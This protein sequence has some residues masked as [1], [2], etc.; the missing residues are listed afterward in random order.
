MAVPVTTSL[1]PRCRSSARVL[2]R[3]L[4]GALMTSAVWPAAIR[5]TAQTPTPGP[6]LLALLTTNK[7]CLERGD[8]AT[9]TVGETII[10]TL[11]IRSATLSQAN[12]TL[13]AIRPNGFIS[14][15]SLG[16]L[17]TNQTFPI[18]AR[19]GAPAG[20]HQL[21]LS[22]RAGAVTS[23][24][25]CTF[26][27]VSAT[28]TA[29]A[30]STPT[31]TETPTAASTTPTSTPAAALQPH[32]TT[33]RGCEETG[34]HPMFSIGEPITVSFDIA[35]DVVPQTRATLSDI[36][37]NGFVNVFPFGTV[38]TNHI[39]SF[40]GSIAPPTGLEVLQLRASSFGVPWA[41]SFCSFSVVPVP[42]RTRIP[43]R[44]PT[45]TR[46][47]PVATATPTP[48]PTPT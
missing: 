16:T 29:T 17:M 36:L 13:F 2:R 41:T 44:T 33:N 32:I 45:R 35:S 23:M 25:S 11:S 42:T 47:V 7:G 10:V 21:L 37:S 6:Q 3:V 15:F 22:A 30:T 31:A 4:I 48:T 18:A 12:A 34:Q 28:T 38:A 9:F 19:V 39:Y 40:N 1:D 5:A 26:N 27:V 24:R 8:E 20:F 43:T 46:T 14:V